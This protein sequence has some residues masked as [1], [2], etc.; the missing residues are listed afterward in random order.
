VVLSLSEGGCLLRTNE[1]LKKG[2]K[3]DLQFALPEYGLV[4]TAAECRYV[5]R[6]DAG[7]EFKSPAPDIRQSIAYFVT[8][9]LAETQG[10]CLT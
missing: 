1:I 10:T 5:R 4:S 8:R 2:A 3:L 6:G 7:I 9:Q